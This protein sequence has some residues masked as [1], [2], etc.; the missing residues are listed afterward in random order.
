MRACVRACV[1]VEWGVVSFPWYIEVTEG[2]E[3]REVHWSHSPP[4]LESGVVNV[5]KWPDRNM[6]EPCSVSVEETSGHSVQ[7]RWQ[8]LS[9]GPESPRSQL[10]L[11]CA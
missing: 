1:L 3:M 8:M 2:Q 6:T 11:D 4:H 10:N 5:G 9:E 7:T